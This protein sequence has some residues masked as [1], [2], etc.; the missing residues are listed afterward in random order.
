[1]SKAELGNSK[2]EQLCGVEQQH[3]GVGVARLSYAAAA[4]VAPAGTLRTGA[5]FDM[6]GV[7]WIV[8]LGRRGDNDSSSRTGVAKAKARY[9]RYIIAERR[10]SLCTE[11]AADG[12]RTLPCQSTWLSLGRNP[13]MS[14]PDCSQWL[15]P[16]ARE[17]I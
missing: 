5:R 2:Q 6:V 3:L 8:E 7:G 14:S 1:M 16:G 13:F 17:Y 12:S 9:S 4:W 15:F 11:T 10:Q